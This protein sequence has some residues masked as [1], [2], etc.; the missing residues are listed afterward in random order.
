MR[1]LVAI[2]S[3]LVVG[4]SSPAVL[5]PLSRGYDPEKSLKH[6]LPAIVL[7]V[8]E[9]RRAVYSSPLRPNF[10]SPRL[11]SEDPRIVRVWPEAGADGFV[12]VQ[13]VAPGETLL[14]FGCFPFPD[15]NPDQNPVERTAWR[16]KLRPCLS[17][18]P[19]NDA[20]FRAIGDA[21]LNKRSLGR[22][23]QG[24]LRVIVEEDRLKW[25]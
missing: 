12:S 21:S 16:W 3:L 19:A 14:H 20:N 18:A 13:A 15:W 25:H 6:A 24:A 17:P 9:T 22:F 4:C 5:L 23:S 11:A 10:G 8:G 7:Q 1:L 2:V